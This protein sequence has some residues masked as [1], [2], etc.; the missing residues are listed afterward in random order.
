VRL[1]KQ[2]PI[3]VSRKR[4]GAEQRIVDRVPHR[5]QPTDAG[6][7]PLG[8]RKPNALSFGERACPEGLDGVRWQPSQ[9]VIRFAASST[10]TGGATGLSG[11]RR[12]APGTRVTARPANVPSRQDN[13]SDL[14]PSQFLPPQNCLAGGFCNRVTRKVSL[15]GRLGDST[16]QLFILATVALGAV[17][18]L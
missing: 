18:L 11:E 3:V 12:F 4:V 10:P 1:E 2:P 14:A 17:S 15:N 6:I 9:S 7:Q 16:R 13:I 5:H 8:S